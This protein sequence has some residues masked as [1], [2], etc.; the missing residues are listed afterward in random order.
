VPAERAYHIK[1][2]PD[3]ITGRSIDIG[4]AR[5]GDIPPWS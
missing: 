4:R 1:I 2:V 5:R 3:S